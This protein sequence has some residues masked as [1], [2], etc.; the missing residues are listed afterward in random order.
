MKASKLNFI[1]G[2][3]PEF[4]D[5]VLKYGEGFD[6]N[7]VISQSEYGLF[8][9]P[10]GLGE[11]VLR[12]AA[13]RINTNAV[14]P[15][16]AATEMDKVILQAVTAKPSLYQDLMR[17][18]C[19]ARMP[20]GT[21]ISRY[22]K[23]NLANDPA[24]S[25]D[26]QYQDGKY[27]QDGQ[28]QS[29]YKDVAIP[30]PLLSYDWSLSKRQLAAANNT[31]SMFGGLALE[32]Q[33]TRAKAIGLQ[34]GIERLLWNGAPNIVINNTPL[35]GV[36]TQPE[37]VSGA[38]SLTFSK[39][40]PDLFIQAFLEQVIQPILNQN[41]DQSDLMIYYSSN[42]SSVFQGDYL[43]Q[44]PLQTITSRLDK[45]EGVMGVKPSRWLSPSN[46]PNST[47]TGTIVV[48]KMTP[49][50][51]DLA[52]ESDI[53]VA[54]YANTPQNVRYAMFAACAPRIKIDY[55]GRCGIQKATLTVE[56]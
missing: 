35:Y 36:L 54:Q 53:R 13:A 33:E 11:D 16:G 41:Y 9:S 28:S 34:N 7:S 26:F 29:D 27:S 23:Q 43:N 30:V 47:S 5:H 6:A 52:I 25:M 51:I 12:E 37:V 24:V 38:T 21:Y 39:S 32:T 8:A 55:Y 45:I 2:G 50:V 18:G 42:L 19:T 3:S 4:L 22:S 20:F 44:L 14:M 40:Q 1:A 56:D 17:A 31:T 46:A 15:L 10:E 48:V 49:D